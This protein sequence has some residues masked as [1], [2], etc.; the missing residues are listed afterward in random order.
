MIELKEKI[1][2]VLKSHK[3]PKDSRDKILKH[4]TDYV[5]LHKKKWRVD[6]LQSFNKLVE[7]M[8][9]QQINYF[10]TKGKESLKA[11]KKLEAQVDRSVKMIK[12]LK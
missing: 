5:N 2:T 10:K 9:N 11:S 4:C 6:G 7:E 8:R 1:E 12:R 3:V